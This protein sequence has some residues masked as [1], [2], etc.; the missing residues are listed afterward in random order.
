MAEHRQHQEWLALYPN[1]AP[2]H[3]LQVEAHLQQCDECQATLAAYRAM[4][5]ALRA[6]LQAKLRLVAAQP[7]WVTQPSFA[8]QGSMLVRPTPWLDDLLFRLLQPRPLTLRLTAAT[9]LL[10]LVLALSILL[11]GWLPF[12]Q[13][14][15][16]STPTQVVDQPTAEALPPLS[17]PLP[18]PTATPTLSRLVATLTPVAVQ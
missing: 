3:K 14:V 4:D 17:G 2:H 9:T 8:A 13:P 5:V 1:L 10:V 18:T 11:G 6:H 7:Q 12:E 15:L 16:A